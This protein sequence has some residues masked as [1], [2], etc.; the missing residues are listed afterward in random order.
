MLPSTD[1]SS[2]IKIYSFIG[3]MMLFFFLKKKKGKEKEKKDLYKASKL[4]TTSAPSKRRQD[5]KR[6]NREQKPENKQVL[7]LTSSK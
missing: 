3:L 6:A 1:V 7:N 4:A 5:Y 2:R